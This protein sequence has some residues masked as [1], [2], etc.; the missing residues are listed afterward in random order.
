MSIIAGIVAAILDPIKIAVFGGLGLLAEWPLG[1]RI[2]SYAV[3]GALALGASYTLPIIYENVQLSPW[4]NYTADFDYNPLPD[5]EGTKYFRLYA[6]QFYGTRSH[7]ETEAIK[8]RIDERERDCAILV[9]SQPEYN[10]LQRC[11]QHSREV[12]FFG[13]TILFLFGAFAMNLW[14]RRRNAKTGGGPAHDQS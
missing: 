3:C 6:H 7:T 2:A 12:N 14:R 5:I 13:G 10:L 1:R 11:L 9:G 4:G 8:R